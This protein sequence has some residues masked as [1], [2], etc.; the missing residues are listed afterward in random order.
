MN[1]EGCVF[2]YNT[3]I[4]GKKQPVRWKEGCGQ[5]NIGEPLHSGEREAKH[6]C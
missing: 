4:Y 2:A 6:L 3:R 1:R 5:Y